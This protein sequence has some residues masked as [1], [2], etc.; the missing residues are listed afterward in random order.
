[1]RVLVTGGAGFIGS[2]LA[3]GLLANG[4]E[5]VIIDNLSTGKR[6]NVP[7]KA[8]FVEADLADPAALALIP[9]GR[10][11]AVAHLAA[12]SSGTIGQA[13]PY[14]DLRV[15]VGAT[16]LLAHWCRARGVKR[17]VYTSS[18]T[19]YG[20]GNREPVDE[21]AA[22]AP[23]GY[24]G[25]SKLA[26]EN[27]LRLAA[28]EGLNVTSFRL[29]NVYGRGQNL[30]NLYQ[31][32]ASIYLAYLLKGV[33]VPVTGSFDRYRDF[34]HVDDVVVVLAESLRRPA[35]PSPVYNIGTG[36][37]T[38]VREILALLVKAMGLPADHPVEE[39]AGSPSD[40]FGSVANARRARDEL[41]WSPRIALADGIADMV[42]WAKTQS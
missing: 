29:Y 41:G 6:A 14:A 21:S 11:D 33:T 35:T 7:A 26:A 20:Q 10:Y 17:F 31:G 15:N 9:T 37:K 19:V 34:V 38:T 8:A 13:D 39:Q 36:R 42:A 30:G 4:H 2:A 28:A 40:V 27:Y 1:M 22:C 23:V 16:L 18:M 25:A 24:Y 3:R 32:M 5:V 12:Q